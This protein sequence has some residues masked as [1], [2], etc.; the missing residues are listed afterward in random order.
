MSVHRLQPRRLPEQSALIERRA[1]VTAV[2]S[3]CRMA[4][5]LGLSDSRLKALILAMRS[6]EIALL[7]DDEARGLLRDMKL[8]SA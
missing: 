7:T 6:D 5:L 4:W 2:R 8:E 1:V 3:L